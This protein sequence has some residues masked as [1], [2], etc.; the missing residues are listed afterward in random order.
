MNH[1]K[2]TESQQLRRILYFI[3]NS[4]KEG[5]STSE[6]MANSESAMGITTH[7]KHRAKSKLLTIKY[8]EDLQKM[9]EIFPYKG[10]YLSSEYA[11]E[12]DC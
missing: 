1:D 12:L 8:L 7:G 3:R 11:K 2:N 6:I 10:R 4:K 9:G 5:R